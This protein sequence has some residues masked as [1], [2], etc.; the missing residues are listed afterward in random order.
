MIPRK[1][2]QGYVLVSV[3]VILLSV[4]AAVMAINNGYRDRVIIDRATD[5]IDREE[6]EK[7]ALAHL[8]AYAEQT[9]CST[10]PAN[11]NISGN[12]DGV[13]YQLKWKKTKTGTVLSS[14]YSRSEGTSHWKRKQ[15]DINLYGATQSTSWVLNSYFSDFVEI[16]YNN[17]GHH[18]DHSNHA[19]AKSEKNKEVALRS[20]KLGPLSTE[21]VSIIKAELELTPITLHSSFNLSDFKIYAI[22]YPWDP[23]DV[24]SAYS[25]LGN[26]TPWPSSS[27]NENFEAL[28]TAA[29]LD[30]DKVRFDITTL[31]NSWIKNTRPN[32]GWA[33]AS[34]GGKITWH[35]GFKT[36]NEEKLP[37][38]N[39]QYRCACGEACVGITQ[40][41][42]IALGSYRPI[43]GYGGTVNKLSKLWLHRAHQEYLDKDPA[44]P[45]GLMGRT[46]YIAAGLS[47]FSVPNATGKEVIG[48]H[49]EPTTWLHPSH[50]YYTLMVG[51][52][53]NSMP[54]AGSSSGS[55]IDGSDSQTIATLTELANATDAELLYFQSP[56]NLAI[57]QSLEA[58]TLP[59]PMTG[60]VD[61][62]AVSSHISD[63]TAYVG[64]FS[65]YDDRYWF[66][67][68]I[69]HRFRFQ[70]IPIKRKSSSTELHE[71]DPARA[72]INSDF[73]SLNAERIP[74]A[75]HVIDKY[76]FIL[77]AEWIVSSAPYDTALGRL[78][79]HD[80]DIV[81]YNTITET[82]RLINGEIKRSISNNVASI[83]LFEEPYPPAG[84]STA[85]YQAAFPFFYP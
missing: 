6:I 5:P 69:D 21:P 44:H 28:N 33:L 53:V 19:E 34:S 84:S 23:E 40:N 67:Q 14:K 13:N 76:N 11:I 12:K 66:G 80:G 9:N 70:D 49:I 85:T 29:T 57:G 55:S 43:H 30:S 74:D 47:D 82:A 3:T 64:G 46:V 18:H 38:I 37:R 4:L 52:S 81:L 39:V 72:R 50:H 62:Q 73:L 25:G 68:M 45:A 15:A 26:K 27:L 1:T 63:N 10:D 24:T 36:N 32:Y 22:K 20:L 59:A 83:A 48:L 31:L 65:L 2:S 78:Q 16:K 61:A 51:A 60:P 41:E 7:S 8:H 17:R 79:F 77:S 71:I 35:S 54:R 56:A 42:A 58:R 75:L